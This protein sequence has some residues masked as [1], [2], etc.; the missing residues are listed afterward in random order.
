MLIVDRNNNQ[1]SNECAFFT[2][3]VVDGYI[4]SAKDQIAGLRLKAIVDGKG[5]LL[6]GK[7]PEFIKTGPSAMR[8]NWPLTSVEGTLEGNLSE[9]QIEM[10]LVTPRPIDWFFDLNT[11]DG[12]KLPFTRVNNKSLDCRF[13]GMNDSVKA[14]EGFFTRPDN[15]GILRISPQVN[16]ITLNL[17]ETSNE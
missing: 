15:P 14:S 12:I 2:L 1:D 5:I 13:E 10:K 17:A 8:I 3:P 9:K 4:W 16:T 11:A 6:Q 7:D